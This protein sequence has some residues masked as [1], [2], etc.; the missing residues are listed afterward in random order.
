M[1]K[2]F[3]GRGG[4]TGTSVVPGISD[5][6]ILQALLRFGTNPLLRQNG[7][8]DCSAVRRRIRMVILVP[9]TAM[10]RSEVLRGRADK[11][12]LHLNRK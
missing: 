9:E 6:S 11:F 4:G 7:K 12:R 1:E 10:W 3:W 2:Y 8:L 5:K